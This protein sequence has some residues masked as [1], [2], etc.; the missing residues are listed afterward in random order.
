MKLAINTFAVIPVQEWTPSLSYLPSCSEQTIQIDLLHVTLLRLLLMSGS[1]LL[2]PVFPSVISPRLFVSLFHSKRQ[3]K[4]TSALSSCYSNVPYR[5]DK[6]IKKT[7]FSNKKRKPTLWYFS[8]GK[9]CSACAACCNDGPC[10]LS[11]PFWWVLACAGLPAGV[12]W[13]PA[14]TLPA[15]SWLQ[16]FAKSSWSKKERN[17]TSGKKSFLFFSHEESGAKA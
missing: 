17:Y 13:S 10:A 5:I 1:V 2:I 3:Q 7:I 6:C 12:S 15:D 14:A 11:L 4:I 8:A 16:I 9:F